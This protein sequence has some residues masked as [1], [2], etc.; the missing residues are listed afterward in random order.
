MFGSNC[1]KHKFHGRKTVEIDVTSVV[2]HY[3][4]GA[5]GKYENEMNISSGCHSV[6]HSAQKDDNC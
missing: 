2:I 5:T 4:S 6:T 1:P 3:N